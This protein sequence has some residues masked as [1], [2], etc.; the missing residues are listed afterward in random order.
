MMVMM[1]V[2]TLHYTDK[3]FN[4][5][6]YHYTAQHVQTNKHFSVVVMGVLMASAVSSVF[7]TVVMVTVSLTVVGVVM[8]V[9][10]MRNQ[11]QE[12]IT[13]QSSGCKAEEHL[14]QR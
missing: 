3:L 6:E 2:I 8:G 11:V 13:Q 7:V 10:C 9:K 1:M 5:H 4:G 12:R 14:K